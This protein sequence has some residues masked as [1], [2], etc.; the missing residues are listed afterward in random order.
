MVI[1][2]KKVKTKSDKM[3]YLPLKRTKLHRFK[4]I[5][6][7]GGGGVPPNPLAMRMAKQHANSQI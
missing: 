1:F 5:F 2:G 4:K 7:G 3:T 6:S